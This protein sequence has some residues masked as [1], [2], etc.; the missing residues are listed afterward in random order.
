MKTRIIQLVVVV[1]LGCVAAAALSS[2]QT[3]KIDEAR[4]AQIG[5]IA[6]NYAEKKGQITPEDAALAREAGKIL[7]APTPEQ[8]TATK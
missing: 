2:C 7:L 8:V 6:L 1:V 5:E 4:L 3:G